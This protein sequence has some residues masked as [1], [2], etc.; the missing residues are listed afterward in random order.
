MEAAHDFGWSV[1]IV[2]EAREMTFTHLQCHTFRGA[3]ASLDTSSFVALNPQISAGSLVLAGAAAV[4]Q[5]IGSQVACKLSIEHFVEGIL[6]HCG[7]SG[8]L[9]DVAETE[10]SLQALEAAFK[11]A[12]RSV[13]SFGHSLAAGGR[14][15]A[16]F[17]GLVLQEELIA[18][19]R[20]GSGSAYLYRAGE[21]FP[22]F[23]DN[24]DLQADS[25]DGY[26]GTQSMVSVELASVSVEGDDMI[27]VFSQSLSPKEEAELT[28]L[29]G[30]TPF[31]G[32]SNPMA[33]ISQFLFSNPDDVAFAHVTKIGPEAIYLRQ[34][35]G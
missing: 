26:L 9:E 10:P 8:D 6:D 35:V 23:E 5:S 28:A 7:E 20:V 21:L 13:Y 11:R 15:A 4:K 24:S 1:G 32:A 14:M 3:K 2:P 22:F 25:D 31:E 27:F 34:V 33:E 16:S 18:A 29:I 17:L 30:D 12:N 19:G